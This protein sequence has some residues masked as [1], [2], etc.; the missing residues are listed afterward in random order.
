MSVLKCAWG[1]FE[2]WLCRYGMPVIKFSDIYIKVN[3]L[4]F[5]G[6]V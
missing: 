4:V 2:H 5:E 1:F 6:V 3:W